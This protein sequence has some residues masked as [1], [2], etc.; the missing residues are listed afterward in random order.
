[1]YSFKTPPFGGWPLTGWMLFAL[2][3]MTAAVVTQTPDAVEAAR[4]VVRLTARTSLVLFVL[5]FTASSLARLLPSSPTLWLLRNRRYLGVGFAGSH[6]IHALALVTLASLDPALFLA[7]TNPAAYVTG[8]LAYLLIIL[9][10][11]T[12]FDRAAAVIGPKV[13][14]C[15][16][17]VG[18]WYIWISFALNFGK[19]F[20]M[21]TAYWPA[22][23]VIALAL[24]I[25]LVA[26]WRKPKRAPTGGTPR[27]ARLPARPARS[28]WAS[29]PLPFPNR[30]GPWRKRK[31]IPHSEPVERKSST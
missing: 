26:A 21:N 30:T 4:L 6:L 31:R 25:R 24:V 11:L 22:M 18:A 10:T 20:A 15:L 12:S 28:P 3:S 13:W 1:M 16:H 2:G 19:R 7:L 5:A 29:V 8:G 9:M 14:M 27:T 17:T 23:I